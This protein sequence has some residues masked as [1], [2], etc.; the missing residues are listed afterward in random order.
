MAVQIC[1]VLAHALPSQS[2]TVTVQVP[3]S[4]AL[5]GKVREAWLV[6]VHAGERLSVIQSAGMLEA[7]PEESWQRGSGSVP[8]EPVPESQVAP[9]TIATMPA[10]AQV[11]SQLEVDETVHAPV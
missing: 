4:N 3:E 6:P 5:A 11:R 9:E 1:V 8:E 2:P 10:D 7:V